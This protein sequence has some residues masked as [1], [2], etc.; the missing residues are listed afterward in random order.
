VAAQ[1]DAYNKLVALMEN[2]DYIPTAEEMAAAGM[3]ES[4]MQAIMKDY[5]A[6]LQGGGGDDYSGNPPPSEE[7]TPDEI[8][9]LDFVTT[10]WNNQFEY[11]GGRSFDPYA[12]VKNTDKLTAAQKAIANETIKEFEK[13]K[14][15]KTPN[16]IS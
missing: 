5:L 14:I 1:E 11:G 4:H 13:E 15:F 12:G 8:A 10:M 6:S 16:K 9:A 3:P 7:L 2:Y